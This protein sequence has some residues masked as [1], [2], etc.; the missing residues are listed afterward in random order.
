VELGA[1]GTP[2][3]RLRPGREAFRIGAFSETGQRGAMCGGH[4]YLLTPKHRFN[5]R[6]SN[7]V[8]GIAWDLAR[9]GG[10]RS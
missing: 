3:N 9:N 4:E 5:K 7:R 10:R 8:E 1:K 2:R 6:F